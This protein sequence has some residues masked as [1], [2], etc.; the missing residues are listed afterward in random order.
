MSHTHTHT[1]T[2]TQREEIIPGCADM[3]VES[4]S[5]VSFVSEAFLGEMTSC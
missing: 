1:H 2:H 4:Y 5:M 3:T